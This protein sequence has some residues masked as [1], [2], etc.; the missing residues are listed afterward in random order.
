MKK[1]AV[2]AILVVMVTS[3]GFARPTVTAGNGLFRV[4]NAE[5]M[6]KG[7]FGFNLHFAGD[8]VG[9][10]HLNDADFSTWDAVIKLGASW[11]PLEFLELGVVPAF[12]YYKA[13]SEA[14]T[15]LGLWD[16]EINAKA[17]YTGLNVLKLGLQIKT[18][19]P[20]GA[21]VFFPSDYNNGLDI[22]G[23]ALLTADLGDVM[24]FPLKFH[25]NA[26]YMMILDDIAGNDVSNHLPIGLG[27]EAPTKYLT[28]LTELYTE[29]PLDSA[30]NGD[31]W[32]GPGLR[33]TLPSG[34]NFDFGAEFLILKQEDDLRESLHRMFTVGISWSPPEKKHVP[35]GDVA[36]LVKDAETGQG[37]VADVSY[38]GP[39]MGVLSAGTLGFTIDSLDPGVYTFEVTAD[40]YETAKKTAIVSDGATTQVNF[41]LEP[42]LVTLSGTVHDRETD[43]G[44]SAILTF[45]EPQM[46]DVT[47]DASTGIYE[48]ELKPGTYRI[49]VSSEG[50][51]PQTA[52][53]IVGDD[54]EVK[55]FDL[56]KKGMKITFRGVNFET[57]KSIILTESYPILDEAAQILKDNPGIRVE[58]GGHTDSRGSDS[59]NLNLSQ[60]RAAAVR[61]Y[62]IKNHEIE[63]NRLIAKGYGETQPVAPNDTEENMYKNRR[64]EFT[65]LGK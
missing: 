3:T 7:A 51:L 48:I 38:K 11:T 58:I 64:V 55:D 21:E 40:G 60:D 24:T 5:N 43:T 19:L 63:S 10:Y 45:L 54:G 59:N 15:E 13:N 8:V 27:I 42:S 49:E 56:I 41:E 20:L 52:S 34:I 61:L 1:I 44:L 65:I 18:L 31:I 30:Q 62:L 57:G 25:L 53:I 4:Q 14:S 33:L 9:G 28:L 22:G 12:G 6:G 16:A 39:E 46:P 47:T 17:S 37:I 35:M 2:I 36:G 26:G 50:Y 23:R 29:Q 32:L